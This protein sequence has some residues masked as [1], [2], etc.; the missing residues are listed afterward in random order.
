LVISYNMV[1]SSIG[2]IK[3]FVPKF[4][5]IYYESVEIQ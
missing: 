4:Y 1:T 2:F 3:T 5:I